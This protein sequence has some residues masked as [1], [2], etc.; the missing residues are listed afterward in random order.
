MALSCL[1]IGAASGIPDRITQ[2]LGQVRFVEVIGCVSTPM[3]AI[4]WHQTNRVNFFV[5]ELASAEAVLSA[6][7]TLPEAQRPRLIIVGAEES[8]FFERGAVEP[9]LF[10]VDS[11]V[12]SEQRQP[13]GVGRSGTSVQRR[14]SATKES[15]G[16]DP[17]NTLN[18]ALTQGYEVRVQQES[19]AALLYVRTEG[20]IKRLK[21]T[22][23]LVIEAQKDYLS[24]TARNT[25]Y[26][27]LRSLKSVEAR[28]DPS[29][30]CRVHRSYIVL[31]EAIHTIDQDQIWVDG[32]ETAIPIGPNYRKEL[33][34][35]LEI[36]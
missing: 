15:L 24:F 27:V 20:G 5:S 7:Q 29:I 23:L 28:L 17:E 16:F 11:F 35:R 33:L 19:F 10:N 3:A 26:R 18:A 6:L 9:I 8:Y 13:E 32:V 14:Q 25:S 34:S 12:P 1:Y 2:F 4:E 22:D 30:H 36:I 21:R 31:I